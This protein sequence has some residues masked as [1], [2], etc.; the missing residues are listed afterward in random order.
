ML[1]ERGVDWKA[2]AAATFFGMTAAS[3]AGV[4]GFDD[5][6]Q[7]E[8]A[9]GDD[10]TLG[11]DARPESSQH[12]DAPAGGDAGDDSPSAYESSVPC[13]YCGGCCSAGQCT[14]GTSPAAC[15]TGGIACRACPAPANGSA[16]C[17]ST[18]NCGYTCN[19]NY[20]V[21]GSGC[22]ARPA[23]GGSCDIG[24]CD[25]SP[26]VAGTPLQSSCDPLGCVAFVCAGSAACCTTTW[27]ITCVAVATGFCPGL[28]CSGC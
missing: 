7:S 19:T 22:C 13:T 12:D 25:H 5:L 6:M 4:L 11:D 27:D 15:G 14:N 23:E 21:C 1:R 28:V 16:A 24:S 18:G 20:V 3:C 26:C 9:P 8:P 10:A 17:D 2:L